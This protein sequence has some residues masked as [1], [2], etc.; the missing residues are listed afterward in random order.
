MFRNKELKEKI[1]KAKIMA[2]AALI[3]MEHLNSDDPQ[4]IEA[5]KFYIRKS[6]EDISKNL[7]D[8]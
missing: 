6:L 5:A 7:K 1:E 2:D 8:S 4:K 3:M